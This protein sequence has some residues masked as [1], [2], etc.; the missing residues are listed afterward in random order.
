MSKTIH[1]PEIGSLYVD[2]MGHVHKVTSTTKARIYCVAKG[3]KCDYPIS[4]FQSEFS[5][6]DDMLEAQL[7]ELDK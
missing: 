4:E 7:M 5:P 1:L 3:R 6:I 2:S